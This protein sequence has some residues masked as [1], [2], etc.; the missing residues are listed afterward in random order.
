M[1]IWLYRIKSEWK[2][3]SR[4]IKSYSWPCTGQLQH[5]VFLEVW[6][7]ASL[8]GRGGWAEGSE[9]T[10]REQQPLPRYQKLPQFKR[11]KGWIFSTWKRIHHWHNL[12]SN[13]EK[14]CFLLCLN[15]DGYPSETPF[16]GYFLLQISESADHRYHRI[17]E[18]FWLDKSSKLME[19]NQSFSTT[20]FTIKPCPHVPHPR[21]S[22]HFQGMV[23][24]PFRQA[25][26]VPE[27]PFSE[28]FF[29]PNIQSLDLRLLP[30]PWGWLGTVQ[31]GLGQLYVLWLRC[32]PSHEI[33]L[34]TDDPVLVLQGS[35]QNPWQGVEWEEL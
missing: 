21:A 25:V 3:C 27:H 2:G 18:L 9:C 31:D 20:I 29:S 13:I 7:H 17:T 14:P 28:D 35:K 22:E 34:C 30:T 32:V 6:I 24:A 16:L 4:I 1:R 10:Q 5:H 33:T 12:A 11:F 26:P 15:E 19:S 8:P 23:I